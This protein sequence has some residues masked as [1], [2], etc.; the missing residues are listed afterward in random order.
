MNKITFEKIKELDY[1]SNEAYKLLRTNLEFC[2]EDIK[3]IMTTSTRPDEGKSTVSFEL[4]RAI[5]DDNKKV[6]LLDADM[7]KTVL[8][9]VTG[10]RSE[11]EIKGLSHY[12]SGQSELSDIVYRSSNAENM[13]VI[14]AGPSTPNPTE[15]LN[16]EKFSSLISELRQKYD[17]VVVD[18]PPLGMVIDA[19]IIARNV[20]GTIIVVESG[21]VSNRELKN[22]KKQLQMADT[23]ILGA[24]LNKVKVSRNQYYSKYYERYEN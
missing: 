21:R 10:A 1:S 20:D 4:A 15:L 12:L 19:A 7:R 17:Y 6:L 5:A 18:A 3:V 13:D 22:V 23:R 2:G 14:F 8:V 24:V 9:S 11:K 16:G